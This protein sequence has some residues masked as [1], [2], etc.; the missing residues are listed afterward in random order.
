MGSA[1]VVVWYEVSCCVVSRVGGYD[2]SMNPGN[3]VRIE[4]VYE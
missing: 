3:K 2:E 4:S 1:S